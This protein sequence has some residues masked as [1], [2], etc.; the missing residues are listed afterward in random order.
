LFLY[1]VYNSSDDS[2]SDASDN[3]DL[4]MEDEDEVMSLNGP[5]LSFSGEE[6]K[7]RFTQYSMTS[8]VIRRNEQL[9]LL[10]SRFEQVSLF[11][12]TI[13]FILFLNLVKVTNYS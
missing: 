7:S 8:S 6:T 12:I 9:S 1:F 3:D 4:D 5:Q 2:W 13:K 11:N 10:D